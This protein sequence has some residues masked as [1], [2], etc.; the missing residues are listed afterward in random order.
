MVHSVETLLKRNPSKINFPLL[1]LP[2]AKSERASRGLDSVRRSLSKQVVIPLSS[3]R[4]AVLGRGASSERKKETHQQQIEE[5]L[6]SHSPKTL[7]KCVVNDLEWDKENQL[8]GDSKIV[9]LQGHVPRKLKVPV[10]KGVKGNVKSNP[11]SGDTSQRGR[12]Q[13]HHRK[14][15]HNVE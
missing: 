7:R 5:I 14:P 8:R 10:R 6:D 12:R 2:S 15:L 9:R 13:R 4:G 3:A 11:A 1:N